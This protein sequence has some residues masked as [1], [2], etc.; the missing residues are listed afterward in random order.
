MRAKV[1]SITPCLTSGPRHRGAA[2]SPCR[3]SRAGGPQL[4][5]KSLC[6]FPGPAA[7]PCQVPELYPEA[8]PQLCSPPA[9]QHWAGGSVTHMHQ[10]QTNNSLQC[11][12]VLSQ[13]QDCHSRVS[14]TT[15]HRSIL[16]LSTKLLLQCLK[17]LRSPD[18]SQDSAKVRR[19]VS[20]MRSHETQL[21]PRYM[22]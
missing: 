2:S 14:A 16:I 9:Q 12:Q 11:P 1:K 19:Q 8:F 20:S 17:L 3:A 7:S 22:L 5:G 6:P 15:I 4:S 13:P 18:S 10:G 21:Q